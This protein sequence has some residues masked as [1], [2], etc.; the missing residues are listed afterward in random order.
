MLNSRTSLLS[1]LQLQQSWSWSNCATT[2][3]LVALWPR[4]RFWHLWSLWLSTCVNICQ[5]LSLSSLCIFLHKCFPPSNSYLFQDQLWKN[6]CKLVLK[7][8]EIWVLGGSRSQA[9]RKRSCSKKSR[10]RRRL[11]QKGHKLPSNLIEGSKLFSNLPQ[12]RQRRGERGEREEN[13]QERNSLEEISKIW[14]RRW[15]SLQIRNQT[16]WKDKKEVFQF[17][18]KKITGGRGKWKWRIKTIK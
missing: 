6:C 16:N 7:E 8:G 2:V 15:K 17:S 11:W 1:H 9:R 5:L 14:Y 10:R 13:R 3:T 12:L 4:W 18:V